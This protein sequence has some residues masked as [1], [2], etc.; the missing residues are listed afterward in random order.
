[1]AIGLTITRTKEQQFMITGQTK[2]EK[3]Y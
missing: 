3:E 2:S 1:V